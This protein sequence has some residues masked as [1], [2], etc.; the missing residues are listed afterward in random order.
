[1]EVNSQ[2]T[3]IIPFRGMKPGIHPFDFQIG[4]SFFE[5]YPESQ[6]KKGSVQVHLD[7][8]KEERM[9]LLNFRLTGTVQV[10]CD[11]CNEPV[12]I[13]IGGP[14]RLI[15]KFGEEY[16]EQSDEVLIIPEMA[17][18]VDIAPFIYEYVHLLLPLRR[19][20]EE[21]ITAGRGCD[22][23]VIKKLEELKRKPVTDSRWEVLS[24]LKEKD[25]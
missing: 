22:P 12:E 19:V 25:E 16:Q 11:R 1:M 17:Y 6:I 7:L 9:L 23:G 18:Q 21:G 15:M 13:S 3:Y 4:D 14:E 5:G 20:H 8:E 10:P 24:K 2:D